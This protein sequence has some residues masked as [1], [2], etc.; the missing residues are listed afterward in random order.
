MK[1]RR[2]KASR[3]TFKTP[4]H[5]ACSD[6]QLREALMYIHFADGWAYGTDAHIIACCYLHEFDLTHEEIKL[7][8]GKSIHKDQ[9]AQFYRKMVRVTPEGIYVP[10]YKCT[11]AL[12]DSAEWNKSEG[13]SI[14]QWM[15]KAVNSKIDKEQVDEICIHAGLLQRLSKCIGESGVILNF[16]TNRHA[17]KCTSITSKNSHY[18]YI[19]PLSISN[20][21]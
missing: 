15:L 17:I 2:P 20:N 16:K 5:L 4:I 13:E 14:T 7:L 3:P 9:F 1:T 11:Y 6:D 12:R 18:G 21:Y 19:M 10:E 8:N